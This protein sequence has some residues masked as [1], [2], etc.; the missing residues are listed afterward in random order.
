MRLAVLGAQDAA[1]FGVI[2]FAQRRLDRHPQHFFAGALDAVGGIAGVAVVDADH[3]AA[4]RLDARRHQRLERGVVRHGAMAVE[5]ILADVEQHADRGLERR[6]QIDLIGGDFQHVS[7]AGGE[8]R[9]RQGGHADIAAHLHVAAGRGQ[10]MRGERG[11]GRLA[12]GAGD[13]D[14][15]AILA[16]GGALAAEQFDVADDVDLGLVRQPHAPMRLRVGE[17]HAGRQYQR[18]DPGPVDVVQ[19][20]GLQPGALRVGEALCVV[21]EHHHLGAALDQ[22]AGRDEAGF[23]EAE[24][25]DLFAGEGGGGDHFTGSSFRQRERSAKRNPKSIIPACVT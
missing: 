18:R 5:M 20:L 24:D 9:Q 14:Q 11:G 25:G 8:G 6:R 1:A 23:A 7:A 10:Q 21:V 19:V 17:R 15:R 12:V 13:G 2:A 3:R 22:R 4:A 16:V